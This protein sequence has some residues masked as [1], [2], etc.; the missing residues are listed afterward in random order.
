[1]GLGNK[2]G[3]TRQHG[4]RAGS[5]RS[6]NAGR[7]GKAG[8]VPVASAAGRAQLSRRAV[9]SGLLGSG[10]GP[11]REGG[12]KQGQMRGVGPIEE[13]ELSGCTRDGGG[14]AIALATLQQT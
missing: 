2:V 11:G 10:A 5:G 12:W 9:K 14:G 4:R 6:T 1:M 13:K 8:P 3:P 7:E